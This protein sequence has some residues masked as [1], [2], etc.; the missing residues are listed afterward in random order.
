MSCGGKNNKNM[1]ND[2]Q[3]GTLKSELTNKKESFISSAPAEKQKI[4]AEG[5]EDVK[6]SKVV[7]NA[8]QVGDVA[9]NF[10]LSNAAGKNVTLYDELKKGTVILM[11]YRGGWCPYCNMTLHHMQEALPDFKKY[12]AN[13]LAISPEVPDSSI[14]TKEK[15]NL[16][17]E[18][19]SDV[20]NVVAKDY[21]VVFKLTDD[22]A[23]IYEN[24]FGLSDY[25]GNDKAELPLAATYIIGQDKVIK[26]AFLD[27]DYRNRAEP[28]DLIEVLKR[29]K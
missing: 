16:A 7:D 23:N 1:E 27:A 9:L 11:W 19:L 20:G 25:N 26:Y 6:K 21:K 3:V 24:G 15:H 18:V 13:L 17:F 14:T 4:Y 12:N 22:V 2:R 10:T 28:Q 5:L 29:L 8:L